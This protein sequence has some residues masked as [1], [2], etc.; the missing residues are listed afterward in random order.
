MP[1]FYDA[2]RPVFES[3]ILLEYFEDKFPSKGTGVV[4]LSLVDVLLW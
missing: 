4:P 1:C 2:G 3:A